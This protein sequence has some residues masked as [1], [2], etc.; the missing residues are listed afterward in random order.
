VSDDRSAEELEDSGSSAY[1]SERWSDAAQ[2]FLAARAGYVDR[3]D[4]LKAAEMGNN[5]CVAFLKAGNPRLALEAVDGTAQTFDRL[6]DTKR[7]AQAM[8]NQASALEANGRTDEAE[9]AYAAAADRF[10]KLG[11]AEAR[12]D[13]LKAL[14]QLQLKRGRA[15]DA[16]A[17]MQQGLEGSQKLSIRERFLRWLA[18]IPMRILGG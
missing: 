17:S 4:E 10:K 6:G 12:A 9:R 3:G 7:A 1:K 15:I 13:T 5:A 16:L 8:G 14:S 18:R 11:E 2:G